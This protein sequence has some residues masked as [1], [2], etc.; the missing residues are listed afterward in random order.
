MP[1][2]NSFVR[3][4]KLFFTSLTLAKLTSIKKFDRGYNFVVLINYN[5]TCSR[6]RLTVL[7]EEHDDDD[8]DDGGGGGGGKKRDRVGGER[9]AGKYV[10]LAVS[11]L[12]FDVKMSLFA[13]PVEPKVGL[14]NVEC[15]S[16]KLN[17]FF[18]NDVSHIR[19]AILNFTKWV[20]FI[21]GDIFANEET[22]IRG[23]E[24]V[25]LK[26]SEAPA[27][28]VRVRVVAGGERRAKP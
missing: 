10:G 7:A 23:E 16:V 11:H 12:D 14:S 1:Q 20:W 26:R 3:D 15:R 18:N 28:F 2:F 21:I 27:G 19:S 5:I 6:Q 25:C 9:N 24:N 17:T 4:T 8:D 13:G 22:L